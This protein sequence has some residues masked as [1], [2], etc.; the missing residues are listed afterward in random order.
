MVLDI[1]VSLLTEKIA[2]C[3]ESF[4]CHRVS[5]AAHPRLI[6]NARRKQARESLSSVAP[7]TAAF[8]GSWSHTQMVVQ[9]DLVLKKQGRI[10]EISTEVRH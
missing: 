9:E 2:T 7:G 4:C 10:V 1:E 6:G 5:V 8:G 3:E